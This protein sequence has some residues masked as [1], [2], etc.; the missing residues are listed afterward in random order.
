MKCLRTISIVAFATQLASGQGPSDRAPVHSADTAADVPGP[1]APVL[2]PLEPPDNRIIKLPGARV[3][4]PVR[5]WKPA[6][7]ARILTPPPAVPPLPPAPE[8]DAAQTATGSQFPSALSADCSH[9]PPLVAPV[10]EAPAIDIA[11]PSP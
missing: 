1:A 2:R 5:A 9:P 4:R 8:I 3:A 11:P 7:S 6:A 10:P